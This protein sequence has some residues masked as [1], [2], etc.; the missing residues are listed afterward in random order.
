MK[1]N[2]DVIVLGGGTAGC[3]A[4]WHF[5][6]SGLDTCVI[7]AGPDY[8]QYPGGRWPHDILNARV[9]PVTTHDWGFKNTNS[10]GKDLNDI[11]GKVMGGC[12]SHNH[13]TAIWP[14]PD[15][16]ESWG[17]PP[18]SGWSYEELFPLINKVEKVSSDSVTPFRGKEGMMPTRMADESKLS[19]WQNRLIESVLACGFPRLTDL[20]TLAP[21]EGLGR[22]HA[23][24]ANEWVRWNSSFAFIDPIRTSQKLTI[25][26]DTLVD[27]LVIHGGIAS[28]VICRTSS[29]S[30][31]SLGAKRFVLSAGPYGSPLVLL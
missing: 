14:P 20:G 1:N 15:D 8:G 24:I 9:A 25:L 7:E 27:K 11:H 4:A 30:A 12:S 10:S 31:F 3:V 18:N 26:S 22:R 13:S 23:N 21:G 5:V 17:F 2:F 28:E 29:D 6:N 16:F 19:I